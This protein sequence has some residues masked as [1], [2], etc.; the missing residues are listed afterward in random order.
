MKQIF[1]SSAISF[2]LLFG[3][4]LFAGTTTSRSIDDR[5]RDVSDTAQVN[6]LLKDA[7]S[8]IIRNTNKAVRD[9]VKAVWLARRSGS[10]EHIKQSLNFAGKASFYAGLFPEA[11]RFFSEL[12]AFIG[13]DTPPLELATTYNNIGSVQM[14]SSMS[15]YSAEAQKS[16]LK[17][18]H[19]LKQHDRSAK[20]QKHHAALAGI[21]NNLALNLQHK[22]DSKR[23]EDYINKGLALTR[24]KPDFYQHELRLMASYGGVLLHQKRYQE[25]REI[26]EKGLQLSMVNQDPLMEFAFIYYIGTWH[27]QMGNY[28]EALRY[29]TR[30]YEHTRAEGNHTTLLEVTRQLSAVYEKTGDAAKA[31][32]FLQISNDSEKKSKIAE[33]A[34]ELARAELKAGIQALEQ[35][36]K[37]ESTSMAKRYRIALGISVWGALGGLLLYLIY[38]RK[39]RIAQ[40]SGME[41]ERAAQALQLEKELL[42][43][44]LEAKDKHLAAELMQKLRKNELI[45]DVVKK[46]LPHTR[47]TGGETRKTIGDVVKNLQ[48]FQDKAAMEEFE[49]HFLQVERDFYQKLNEICPDLSP[50]ERRLCAF[51]RLNMT[52]K[53]ISALTG[54][55]IRAVEI[56]RTRIRKKLD[57]T[58]TDSSLVEFLSSL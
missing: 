10:K 42:E 38:R 35:E 29:Y 19:Y 48:S 49:M 8:L 18:L 41:K 22:G 53:E 3:T 37:A 13:S 32:K 4:G 40:L 55:S 23:A 24:G 9:A 14:G 5:L 7:E 51:L 52:T 21:Y 44:E 25:S 43:A 16:L 26:W 27:D 33:T 57:L 39:Y 34:Q 6:L 28:A 46:L 56:G 45:E 54:R 58:H 11:A 50:S 2:A 30:Y 1:Y 31:L 12:S 20:D 47:A 17:A 15:K 36:M